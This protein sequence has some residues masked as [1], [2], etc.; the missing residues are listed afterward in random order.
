VDCS[1]NDIEDVVH[2]MVPETSRH[3]EQMRRLIH[4]P[5]NTIPDLIDERKVK[6][7][8][9]MK[10]QEEELL[11]Q[12]RRERSDLIQRKMRMVRRVATM[13]NQ[14]KLSIRKNHEN[15]ETPAPAPRRNSIRR[16]SSPYLKNAAAASML[17]MLGLDTDSKSKRKISMAVPAIKSIISTS[18]S[19]DV[20]GYSRPETS[21]DGAVIEV[22]VGGIFDDTSFD[23]IAGPSVVS[24]GVSSA[25]TPGTPTTRR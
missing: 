22:T 15:Q 12:Q 11:E 21:D 18:S 5:R 13:G 8:A 25:A 17:D 3:Y 6:R 16:S 10:R 9:E 24:S 2:N 14:L 20:I 4:S 23:D 1:I 7:E 19:S